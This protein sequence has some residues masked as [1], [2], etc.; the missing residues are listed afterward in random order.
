MK[1]LSIGSRETSPLAVERL[2][3]E[4]VTRAVRMPCGRLAVVLHLSRLRHPAPRPH[5]RRIARALLQDT[6]A[7]HDGQVFALHNE[8]LVLLCRGFLPGQEM[9]VV[10]LDGKA[11]V[12][13]ASVA[14]PMALPEIL[15][16]L[17]RADTPP[18][19]DLVSVWPLEFEAPMLL[20]YAT[21]RAAQGH[22]VLAT[23]DDVTVQPGMVNA[24]AALV[25]T[26]AISDLM[27]RQTAV[28]LPGRS[29]LGGP[30]P[31]PLFQEVTFSI[32]ALES[33]IATGGHASADP[34][35]FRHL[36]GRMDQRM[37]DVLLAGLGQGGPLDVTQA[38]SPMLHLNLTLPSLN[39]STFARLIEAVIQTRATLGVEIS[40]IEAVADPSGFAHARDTAERTGFTLILD[41]VSHVSM[42]IARPWILRPDLLKLDWSPRLADLAAPE[43]AA[44]AEALAHIGA[45]R[46]ILHR[47]ETEAAI[48]WGL[49][50]GIRRFQ[51]RHV[52]AMLG[53]SRIVGCAHA[54]H[55]ALRQCIERAAASGFAGRVGCRNMALL[56]AGAPPVAL[57]AP[58]PALHV[59]AREGSV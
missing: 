37:L 44:I 23:E 40:L 8:D 32:A 50:H 18:G 12:F 54:D 33:R 17:L 30:A 39:S 3:L 51:G 42:L 41:G 9:P 24:I 57:P 15:G 21:D 26:A 1:A 52:D 11:N 31:R 13:R 25:G 55:C 7:R 10:A 22:F 28:L 46:V 58:A 14:E 48:R 56:D 34:F 4:A 2:L 16:R 45:D 49:A 35:L 59:R 36:A 47:A 29:D 20:T 43:A 53:A 5:H 6:A 27:Q 19:C 38:G